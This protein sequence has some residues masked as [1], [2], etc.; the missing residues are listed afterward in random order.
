MRRRHQRAVRLAPANQYFRADD[1]RGRKIHDRLVVGHE[2]VALDR[3]GELV[4]RVAAGTP[5]A[6]RHENKDQRRRRSCADRRH[7]DEVGMR[8]KDARARDRGGHHD[9]VVIRRIAREQGFTRLR[10]IPLCRTALPD[11]RA[12]RR[13]ERRVDFHGTAGRRYARDQEIGRNQRGE[14]G[15]VG[16]G[17]PDAHAVVVAAAEADDLDDDFAVGAFDRSRNHVPLAKR[18]RE[19]GAQRASV[20]IDDRHFLDRDDVKRHL[21]H[22]VPIRTRAGADTARR[23]IIEAVDDACQPRLGQRD[24]ALGRDVEFVESLLLDVMAE[25]RIDASRRDTGERQPKRNRC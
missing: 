12:V 24:D 15:S 11:P 13:R 23:E 7:H 6:Q 5:G 10:I 1:A 17:A 25:P 22:R 3:A 4:D 16:D 21:V 20:R 19:I 2:L 9:A 8:G 14:P 18:Q